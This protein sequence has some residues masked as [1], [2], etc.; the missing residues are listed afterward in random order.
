MPEGQSLAF[1]LGSTAYVTF[2]S[3]VVNYALN[4]WNQNSDRKVFRFERKVAKVIECI[5]SARDSAIQNWCKPGAA[6]SMSEFHELAAK[7]A[8]AARAIHGLFKEPGRKKGLCCTPEEVEGLIT[9]CRQVITD[10]QLQ[11]K[12][13]LAACQFN[14]AKLDQ[15]ENLFLNLESAVVKEVRERFRVVI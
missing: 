13:R 8:S 9:G 15:I 12:S 1:Y 7:Y 4:K 5:E 14:S 11:D 6:V 2:I 3:V 10:D